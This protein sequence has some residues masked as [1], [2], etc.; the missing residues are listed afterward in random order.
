MIKFAIFTDLHYDFIPDGDERL[1]DFLDVCKKNSIEFIMNLGDFCIPREENKHVLK[2]LNSTSLPSYHALGNHDS[3]FYDKNQ[4][5]DFLNMKNTYY[6]FHYNDIKFIVLDSCFT[7]VSGMYHPYNKKHFKESKGNYPIIPQNQIEWLENELNDDYKKYIIFT[8]H[9]LENDFKNRGIHNKSLLHKLF[10]KY[11]DKSI[12]CFNG[13]DH[14]DSHTI[15]DNRHYYGINGMSYIWLGELCHLK[16]YSDDMYKAYPLLND[17]LLYDK[18][19]FAI[20]SIND[21]CQIA[22]EGRDVGYR[23]VSPDDLSIDGFWNGRKLSSKV[24]TIEVK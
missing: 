19:L 13:H 11:P 23:N 5:L 21:N 2:R 9:S 6:S 8:H 4:I 24:S 14:A 7:E 17:I 22:I 3:D 15:I 10:K 1:N 18:A 16:P 12:S 20:V